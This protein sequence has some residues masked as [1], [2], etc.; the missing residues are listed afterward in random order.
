MNRR[1]ITATLVFGVTLLFLIWRNGGRTEYVQN[2]G[3][4]F[5]TSYSMSY[6][7]PVGSGY[8]D[9]LHQHLLDVVDNSLSTFNKNSVISKINNNQEHKTDEAFEKVF[10]RAL[11][12]SEATGGAFDMTVAPLVNT[13]GFGY[14]NQDEI[15]PTDAEIDS[16][17]QFVGYEKVELANHKIIKQYPEIKL[18]ASAIAK[19]YSVDVAAEFLED[20]GVESYMVEIGGEIRVKGFNSQGKK[21]R[22]GIDKPMETFSLA[23]RQLD[24]II[25][26]SDMALATSGNYR[27]F[28]YKDGKRYS[29]TIDPISGYP[30]NHSLLSATVLAP[31]CM[32]AD[33]LA[34]AFMVMG[35][36]KSMKLAES[37][38]G[39]EIYLIVDDGG[40]NKEVFTSGFEKY[41]NP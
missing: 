10:V 1:R 33:A 40:E 23:S 32:T 19:G 24:T 16:L 18:D 13:W 26:V 12:L 20:K 8:G 27:Q 36:E 6:E 5:G 15:L 39:V 3:F 7:V 34:T 29:H 17:K 30:V 9:E 41:L 14:K 35:A 25:H 38:Q 22:L 21:W 4:I 37:L 11:E 2:N 31:D 28:Y